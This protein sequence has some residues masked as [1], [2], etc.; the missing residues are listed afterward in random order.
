MLLLPENAAEIDG[1]L[2]RFENPLLTACKAGHV[3]LVRLLLSR[4]AIVFYWPLPV[5]SSMG[6]LD[7]VR[8]LLDGGAVDVD[9]RELN[10][11]IVRGV[12][13]HML[14]DAKRQRSVV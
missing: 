3:N 1:Y 10:K 2:E 13:I 8:L 5:A 14:L 6:R 9:D 11:A 12:H 4:G 7:I